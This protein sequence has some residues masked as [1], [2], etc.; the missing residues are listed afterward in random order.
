MLV[1]PHQAKYVPKI[2]I[3]RRRP[4]FA[5]LKLCLP[6]M[7]IVC[8]ENMAMDAAD[9]GICQAIPGG[10]AKAI[11]RPDIKAL[12]EK[13]GFFNFLYII[14]ESSPIAVVTLITNWGREFLIPS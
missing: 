14:R 8:L 10:S 9:R 4:K 2:N 5:G 12:V 1:A 6:L 3:E 11:M 7:W 13:N